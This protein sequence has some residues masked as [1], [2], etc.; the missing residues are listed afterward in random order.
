MELP[1]GMDLAVVCLEPERVPIAL[2]WAA[3][4]GVKAVIVTSSGFRE[5]GGHGYHL[6]E[7]I[8]QV[9]SNRNLTLLGPNCLGV[10]SLVGAHERLAHFPVAGTWQYCLFL[11]VRVYVQCH[12]GL[13]RQRGNRFFQIRQSRQSGHHDEASML[14][15]LSD[16]S[17]TSVI[18]GYLEGMNNGRRFCPHQSH[19][20]ARK[21]GHHAPGWDDRARAKVGP[22]PP[23]VGALQTG[24]ERIPDRPQAGRHIQADSLSSLIWPGLSATQP[25]PRPNLAIVTTWAE[26]ASS[27]PMVRPGR[28]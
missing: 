27:Q 20:H 11:P 13:G 7:R 24:S 9:A 25:L 12:F 3:E 6:E 1:H 4:H 18:I 10:A 15:F 8:V 22:S 23:H 16:D 26:Q 21:T 2:E 17:E 5:I 14:Q 28:T 19:H